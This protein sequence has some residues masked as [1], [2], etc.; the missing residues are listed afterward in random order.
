MNIL[1]LY[2]DYHISI[3]SPGQR[4]YRRGWINTACPFCTGSGKPGNH[5]GFC[6]DPADEYFNA[7]VCYRCGGKRIKETIA[8]L[9][10]VSDDQAKSIIAS[11]GGYSTV[12][13]IVKPK[14]VKYTREAVLPPRT[15]R[16]QDI[17]G[18][19]RYVLKRKFDPDYL[20]QVWGVVATGPSSYVH[21]KI[22]DREFNL[23]YSY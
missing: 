19:L 14:G 13:T 10:R 5:L 17:P 16:I 23:N 2:Q 7:F 22:E 12:P 4:H 21:I 15:R 9:L 3:A 6:V 11:Y 18:A 20:E 1:K 8:A